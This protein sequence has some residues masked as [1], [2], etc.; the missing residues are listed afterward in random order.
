MRKWLI[1]K[2]DQALLKSV[3]IRSIFGI[4]KKLLISHV[5]GMMRPWNFP[6]YAVLIKRVDRWRYLQFLMTSSKIVF[7]SVSYTPFTWPSQGSYQSSSLREGCPWY[8]RLA[9]TLSRVEVLGRCT[10]LSVHLY[11]YCSRKM[12]YARSQRIDIIK[13][14]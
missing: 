4:L 8:K 7:P 6:K 13:L 14:K 5:S 12:M 1:L 3:I 10:P 2:S 9:R 11:A